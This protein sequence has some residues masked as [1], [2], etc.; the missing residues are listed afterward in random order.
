MNTDTEDFNAKTE[1]FH[2]ETGIWPPGRDMPA[3]MCG[4]EDVYETRRLAFDYWCNQQRPIT[5]HPDVQRLIMKVSELQMR[6][7]GA[8]RTF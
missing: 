2:K 1:A 7:D 3:A 8:K 5:E 6:L 4:G